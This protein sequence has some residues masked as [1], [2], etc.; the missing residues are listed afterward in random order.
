MKPQAR[1]DSVGANLKEFESMKYELREQ[2]LANEELISERRNLMELIDNQEQQVKESN[3]QMEKALNKVGGL[4]KDSHE[5]S[6]ELED[7]R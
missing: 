7:I 2:R 5:K 3:R 1:G 4:E 6:L